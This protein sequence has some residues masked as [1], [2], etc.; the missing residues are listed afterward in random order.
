MK[1]KDAVGCF[2]AACVFLFGSALIPFLGPLF[3]LLTPLPFLFYASK[4]GTHEGLKV[5]AITLILLAFLSYLTG[6]AHLMFLSVE[7]CFLGVVLAELFRKRLSVGTT[8]LW[9]TS[10]V[11]ILGFTTL[12]LIGWSKAMGPLDMVQGY[13]RESLDEAAR[14]YRNM[15]M[16]ESQ[17]AEFQRHLKT[18]TDMILKVYLGLLVIGTGFIVWFNVMVS[19]PLFRLTGLEYPDF[20]DLGR[21][22]A[23]EHL[24]WGVIA[25]GFSLFLVGGVIQFL[26]VNSLIVLVAIYVFHGLAILIFYL[27]KLRI[28]VWVRAGIYFLVVFQQLFLLVLALAGLFDQWVDFRRIHTRKAAQ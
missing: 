23:P 7:F 25:S 17:V 24:V 19:R 4:L 28:P 14:V 9:A 1:F 10:L 20:G 8:I 18:L 16:E 3:G 12:T 26:A 2:G 6:Y 13:V 5:S 22:R 27:N 21:W 15:G 11:L